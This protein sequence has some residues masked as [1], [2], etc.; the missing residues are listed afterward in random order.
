MASKILK[1][2][3][4]SIFLCCWLLLVCID[5]LALIYRL[6][7]S[8]SHYLLLVAGLMILFVVNLRYRLSIIATICYFIILIAFLFTQAPRFEDYFH[9]AIWWLPLITIIIA[10]AKKHLLHYLN[11][12]AYT[13]AIIAFS[14]VGSYSYLATGKSQNIECIFVKNDGHFVPL[15]VK[16]YAIL[17]Q[18]LLI[19]ARIPPGALIIG[20]N[21]K[22]SRRWHF[23]I[24]RQRWSSIDQFSKQLGQQT[25]CSD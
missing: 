2:L 23:N 16:S 10:Y 5:R 6:D 18:P 11:L 24:V 21:K 8:I 3:L 15:S 4:I 22:S 12:A 7:F 9:L 14:F 19:K 20:S 17:Y 13:G 25:I 1:P